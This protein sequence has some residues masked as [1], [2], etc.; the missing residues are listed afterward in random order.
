M[1]GK[2][3]DLVR[4]KILRRPKTE[5]LLRSQFIMKTYLERKNQR[6]EGSRQVTVGSGDESDG[7]E[8]QIDENPIENLNM[9]TRS[10]GQLTESETKR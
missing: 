7:R 9:K 5:R 6:Q 8:L 4:T 10:M 1:A 3:V 2:K